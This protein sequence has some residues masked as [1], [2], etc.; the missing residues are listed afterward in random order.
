MWISLASFFACELKVPKGGRGSFLL[1]FLY[2]YI[3][4]VTRCA[5]SVCPKQGQQN[6]RYSSTFGLVYCPSVTIHA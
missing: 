4:L 2:V 5:R 1:I 6:V 3:L